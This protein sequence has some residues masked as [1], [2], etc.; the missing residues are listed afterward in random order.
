VYISGC[1]PILDSACL[2][3]L[4]IDRSSNKMPAGVR[5]ALVHIAREE[6]AMGEEEVR[7]YIGR[8]EEMLH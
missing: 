1:A 2:Q 6:G 3:V 4:T 8:M 7:V 5:A